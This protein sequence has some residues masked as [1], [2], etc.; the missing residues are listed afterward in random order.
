MKLWTNVWT[1]LENVAAEVHNLYF[2]ELK[3]SSALVPAQKRQEFPNS[4]KFQHT[5]RN[6]HHEVDLSG[7]THLSTIQGADRITYL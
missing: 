1:K 3:C 7:V 4:P 5:L 6:C 2:W